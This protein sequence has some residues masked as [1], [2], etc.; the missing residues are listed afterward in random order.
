MTTSLRTMTFVPGYK[1]RFLEKARSFPSD[2]LILDLEDSVPLPNKADARVFIRNSLEEKWHPQEVF[3][4]VNSIDS[5]MLIEDLRATLHAQTTGFMFTKALDEHD[6]IYFDKLLAQLERDA[7]FPV[8]QFKMCPLIETGRAVL[9]AYEMAT[10]STRTVALAFGG[11]DYLTDL[12]G[13]HKEHGT[14]LIVPRSL[15]VMAARSAHVGAIDTPYLDIQNLAGFQKEA[16]LARE[17]G[18]SGQLIIHPSQIEIAN[19]VFTPSEQEVRE[20][21][22]IIEVIH[23]SERLGSGVALLEG[24]LI[25]PPMRK[26]AEH[27]L[28]KMAE[29]Q[30]TI[31]QRLE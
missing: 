19:T 27:I 31:D 30:R 25:G 11:E 15:I 9:R 24:K 12:D 13:L 21:K 6:I 14:S 3:V 1:E 28:N 5:G 16:E 7:G 17:L 26:R 22:Q 23:E 8:G 2:A 20:A 18:F 29:I 10:A 4:R